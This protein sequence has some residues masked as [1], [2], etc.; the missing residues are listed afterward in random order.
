M[1]IGAKSGD[2]ASEVGRKNVVVTR[3]LLIAGLHNVL[4][5]MTVAAAGNTVTAAVWVPQ[6][7][8]DGVCRRMVSLM[9]LRM[10]P[11]GR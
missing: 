11:A 2:A 8:P 3:W 9:R 1:L 7:K 10:E 6:D 4:R 5:C